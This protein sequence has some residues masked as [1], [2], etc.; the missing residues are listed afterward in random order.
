MCTPSSSALLNQRLTTPRETTIQR[1]VR[2]NKSLTVA[3]Q[4]LQNGCCSNTVARY[5]GLSEAILKEL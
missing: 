5:T 4:M 1:R 2:E 3:K